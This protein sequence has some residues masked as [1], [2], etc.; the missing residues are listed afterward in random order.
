M[1]LGKNKP[2]IGVVDDEPS[3][4]RALARLL[5]GAGF[6]V[7]TFASGEEFLEAPAAA[8][9]KLD[10]LVLDVHLRG[11]TGFDVQ[12]ELKRRKNRIPILFI[13]AVD[14]VETLGD[15]WSEKLKKQI[16]GATLLVKPFSQGDL[17][18]QIAKVMKSSEADAHGPGD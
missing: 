8:P 14:F 6:R 12:A 3:V 16:G 17:L 18:H 4:R 10:C 15:E 2:L 11:M 9:S 13:T 1:K 7:E 5:K